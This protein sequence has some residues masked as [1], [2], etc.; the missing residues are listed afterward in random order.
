MTTPPSKNAREYE[1]GWDAYRANR[2]LDDERGTHWRDGWRDS[3]VAKWTDEGD[4]ELA[5]STVKI[6]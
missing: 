2:P 4:A 1:A 5:A 6:T 3:Q